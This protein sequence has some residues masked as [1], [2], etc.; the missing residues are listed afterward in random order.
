MLKYY[1]EIISGIKAKLNQFDFYE[2]SLY[3]TTFIASLLIIVFIPLRWING[4]I[5]QLKFNIFTL[6]MMIIINWA[7]V[8]NK[9]KFAK[10]IF[11]GGIYT[12]LI[13]SIFISGSSHIFW[14]YPITTLVFFIL[15]PKKALAA[16]TIL[17]FIIGIIIFNELILIEWVKIVLSA[18][19]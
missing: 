7:L 5:D 17:I 19:V 10:L 13:I 3:L 15:T 16:T 12:Y 8:N 9:A 11:L 6:F 1:K 18:Q 14:H 4:D 2:S